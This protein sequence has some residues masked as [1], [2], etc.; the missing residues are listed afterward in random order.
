MTREEFEHYIIDG[1]Q[2]TPAAL[3][4]LRMMQQGLI[5]ECDIE[6]FEREVARPDG[7][8]RVQKLK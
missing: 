3:V 2:W 7:V 1:Y 5:P 8:V 6:T 4:A